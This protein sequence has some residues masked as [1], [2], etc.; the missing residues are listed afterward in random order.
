MNLAAGFRM[1][2]YEEQQSVR[3]PALSQSDFNTAG[4]ATILIE[5]QVIITV[6]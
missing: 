4:P 6:Y 1:G 5:C 2:K 3:A